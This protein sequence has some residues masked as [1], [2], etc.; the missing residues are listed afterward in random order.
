MHTQRKP[1]PRRGSRGRLTVGLQKAK[2]SLPGLFRGNLGSKL[3]PILRYKGCGLVHNVANL[4]RGVNQPD[5]PAAAAIEEKN[6]GERMRI[7]L[8]ATLVEGTL[9]V[10]AGAGAD[11][12]RELA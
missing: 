6:A 7:F 2:P 1:A 11:G 5:H 4:R 12:T 3:E 9:A 8:S 10:G